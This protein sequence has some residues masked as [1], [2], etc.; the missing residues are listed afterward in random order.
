MY[1]GSIY[2]CNEEAVVTKGH[3]HSPRL[4]KNV[5][6]FSLECPKIFLPA[7][8]SYYSPSRS[9]LCMSISIHC[10]IIELQYNPYDIKLYTILHIKSSHIILLR[11]S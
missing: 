5:Y 10:F 6:K 11:T 8:F 7:P 2:Y 3:S 4:Y 9:F 1:T